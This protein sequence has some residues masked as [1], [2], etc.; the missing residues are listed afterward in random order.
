MTV[1]EM[2][3]TAAG[4][5]PK[6]NITLRQITEAAHF[7][8]ILGI[9]DAEVLEGSVGEASNGMLSIWPAD[10]KEKPWWDAGATPNRRVKVIVIPCSEK[11]VTDEA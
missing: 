10:Y 1:G 3:C 4:R 6:P 9:W 5:M 11:E 8:R 2:V 7:F